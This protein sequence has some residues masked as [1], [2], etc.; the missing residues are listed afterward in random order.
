[1]L[2]NRAGW[3]ATFAAHGACVL[4]STPSFAIEK[5]DWLFRVR[6]IGVVP[7]S[8]S[9]GGITP[10]LL[11]S[12]LDPQPYGVPEI[13]L[14]YMF[15]DHVGL[16]LIAAT[17]PHG[18]QGTGGIEGLNHVATAWLL[19]P[20][21]TVQYHF[22]PKATFRPYLGVGANYT[23][24]YGENA[25][26]S[27]EAALGGPT[28]VNAGDSFGYAVQAGFDYAISERWFINFDV[29]YIDMSV[30]IELVTGAT[31]CNVNVDINRIIAGIGIGYQF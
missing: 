6:G 3:F 30:D 14:T 16:E 17:S 31:H 20:T 9:S 15:T 10:D 24:T 8:E 5:G 12:G 29:K 4:T 18:F 13:D 19:P 1:M 23:Q 2:V 26:D 22:T 11:T 25:D 28:D 21:L 7:T 27:L